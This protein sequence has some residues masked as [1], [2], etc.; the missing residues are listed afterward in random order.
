[1]HVF[2]LVTV[3]ILVSAVAALSQNQGPVASADAEAKRD[4]A[5]LAVLNRVCAP[6]HGLEPIT[7]GLKT[8]DEWDGVFTQMEAS[9]ATATPQEFQQA[10]DYV[11]RHHS[12]I[13]VNR[14]TAQDLAAWLGEPEAAGRT[15]VDYRTAHGA[16][17]TLDDVKKVPGISA[18]K[19]DAR[20]GRVSF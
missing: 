13:N 12:T 9:G 6:C 1:M 5:E 11:L 4:A 20:K 19:L 7:T 3:F 15:I 8:R 16:F 10:F 17:K 14:A 18:Q 2:P